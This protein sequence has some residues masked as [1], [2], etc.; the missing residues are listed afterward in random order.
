MDEYQT[1]TLTSGGLTAEIAR[2]GAELVSLTDADGHQLMSDGDPAYWTGRAPILFPIVGR[3]NGDRYTLDGQ[4]YALPQHGFARR[5]EFA[6]AEQGDSHARLRLT[7]SPVTRE[8]Y[9]FPFVL[10]MDFVLEGTS[11]AITA[12]ITN[13]GQEPLP[14]SF[15]Y[16]PAFAWPLPFGATREDHRIVFETVE[17]ADICAITPEGLIDGRLPS[18]IV[19]KTLALSDALFADG[20][21]IWDRLDSR[22]VRYGAPTGP[23]LEVDFP[24]TEWLGIWTKPGAAFVC[25]E[26]WAGMADAVDYKGDFRARPGVFEIAPGESRLFRM[27]VQLAEN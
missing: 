25:I 3:L 23:A 20:A 2:L 9:P 13:P 16:H 11:L 7:D 15:G 1:I 8:A 22:S 14:A 5:T 12:T 4:S 24:D 27:H 19:G 10:E 26:P 17:P 6:I 18:P 21:L